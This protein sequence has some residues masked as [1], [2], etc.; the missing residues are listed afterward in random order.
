MIIPICCVTCGKPLAHLWEK[1]HSE[2]QKSYRDAKKP[3][4]TRFVSTQLSEKTIEQ[5]M[6]DE[7]KIERYCCRRT[8]LCHVDISDE[9]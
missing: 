2:V 4:Q 3:P 1:Y 7:L 5:S 8:M 6:L 9:L